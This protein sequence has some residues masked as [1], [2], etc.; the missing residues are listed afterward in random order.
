MAR[1]A[2]ARI[3]HSLLALA[4]ATS[5]VSFWTATRAQEPV[6][7]HN[8]VIPSPSLVPEDM[9]EQYCSRCHNEFDAVAGLTVDDLKATDLALG[10]NADRWEKVLR[11]VATGEMPPDDKPQPE[12]AQRNAFVNWLAQA[13]AGYA[14]MHPD[15]GL[16]TV[17]RLNRVEYANAVRDL[18]A[19]DV[20]FSGELPQDNSGFGFDN[21]A[22][23]LSVSPTLMERYVAVAGKI[24]RMATGIASARVAVTSYQVP[25]D[26][27]VGNSGIPAYNERASADLPLGSRGGGAFRYFAPYDGEYDVTAWLN[28]NSNNETD[29]ETADRYALRVPMT[30][31]PHLVGMSFRRAIAPEQSVQTIR[32]DT[33]KVP[34]PLAKPTML[35]LD[36][37]IDGQKAGELS[38]PSYRLHERYAQQNFPRDVLQIDV[39]GPYDAKGPGKTASRDKI[40]VCRPKSSAAEPACARRIASTLARRAWRTSGDAIDIAPLLTIYKAERQIGD[41]EQGIA[42]MVQTVLVSPRFL[43]LVESDPADA[44]SGS[45]HPLSD[46]ELAARLALFLWSSIPDET[47]LAAADKGSLHRPEVLEAQVTRML[48]DPR[49]DALT[50]NFAG[51]W[52]FLRNLDQQRPDIAI[53]PDFDVRLRQAMATETE[54]FFDHVV[55]TNRPVLDFIKADYAFLNQRLADHYGIPNVRGAAFRKVALDPAWHRGG[56]LGQASILTVTSYGNHTSVVKRGKW[57]LDNMLA[58][59]PPPPPPDVPALK[60]EHDGRLLNAREQL[61]LHRSDPA[62]AACHVRM[63]PIGFSLENFDAVGAWRK[64]DAGQAIDNAAVLPDGTNF[65]GINGLQDILLARKDEF[66][67]AFTERLMTYALGRGIGAQDM[68][69]IRAIAKDAAADGY[70]IRTIIKGIVTSDAFTRRRVPERWTA[71]DRRA[72]R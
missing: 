13:R 55:R 20:D 14:G 3:G 67:R 65:A 43:Y 62:C 70:R 25:K 63:D 6:S 28:S 72:S 54:S 15:P 41:F 2:H 59:P 12:P 21:I 36:I 44:T 1:T 40:F 60:A 42:A 8:G 16:A 33:D 31:G 45:V 56:V 57:V 50:K 29:R 53:F 69:A 10:E 37:W 7:E 19:L 18:L 68:P 35:P 58:A 61:E 26:G 46:H 47:L 22:D 48:D 39:A 66:T 38:V 49:A 5:A 17:R 11:K 51:Q 71:A 24:S 27:S 23:V 52:L 64:S 30:A 34:L 4:A 9:L 32:N